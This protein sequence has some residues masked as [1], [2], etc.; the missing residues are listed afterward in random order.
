MLTL[1]F[2]RD[3][4]IQAVGDLS[5]EFTRCPSQNYIFVTSQLVFGWYLNHETELDN[6]S[7]AICILYTPKIGIYVDFTY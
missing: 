1:K 2:E 3:A 6:Q 7:V 5:L 4:Y